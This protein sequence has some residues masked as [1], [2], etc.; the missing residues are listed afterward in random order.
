MGYADR[1]VDA[2]EKSGGQRKSRR[3]G[4]QDQGGA[5][6]GLAGAYEKKPKPKRQIQPRKQLGINSKR[7]TPTT[8]SR[9]PE[10]PVTLPE[11]AVTFAGIR[12]NGQKMR[13][14]RDFRADISLP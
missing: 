9:S 10:S 13:I 3:L 2:Q 4:Q 5:S 11:S 14:S 6:G 8:R 7:A 1:R 12:N